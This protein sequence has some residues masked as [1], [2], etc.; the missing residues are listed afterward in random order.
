MAIPRFSAALV[1]IFSAIALLI[2]LVG[3]YGFLSYTLA[4]RAKELAIRV[5]VGAS[6][7]QI[8]WMLFRQAMLRST[9]GIAAGLSLAWWL[10]RALETLLFQVRGHNP[11]IF[12]GVASLLLITSMASVLIPASRAVRIDPATALRTE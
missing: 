10:V 7:S 6:A 8:C 9:L 2:A 3:V 5:T 12:G 4:Q 11:A 1:S